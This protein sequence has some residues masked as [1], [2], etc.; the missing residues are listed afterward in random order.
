M[1]FQERLC[2]ELKGSGITQ[3]LLAE[4]LNIDESNI[5]KWKKGEYYPSLEVFYQL[6]LLLD[7]SADYL[8]G[9]QD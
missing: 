3:K 5:T 4:K 9:L 1:K 7:V 8:L 2:L 6:C